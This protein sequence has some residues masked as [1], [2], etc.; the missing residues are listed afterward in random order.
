M[1]EK[2]GKK[3]QA[4]TGDYLKR[5]KSALISLG[6]IGL[7]GGTIAGYQKAGEP[8]ITIE[9][10]YSNPQEDEKPEIHEEVTIREDALIYVNPD[11]AIA[12]INGKSPKFDLESTI[13]ISAVACLGPN[14]EFEIEY[15][16]FGEQIAISK[17]YRRVAVQLTVN[18]V[19]VGYVE[20]SNVY[21]KENQKIKY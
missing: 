12:G 1:A 16:P 8:F 6:I 19:A 5:L 21:T 4:K 14:E 7:A 13:T 15:D 9:H 10:G 17:G 3:A 18:D 20:P 2:D 11:D